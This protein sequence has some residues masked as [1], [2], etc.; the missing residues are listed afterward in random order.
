MESWVWVSSPEGMRA[1]ELTLPLSNGSTRWPCWTSDGELALVVQIRE[2]Q[3]DD[4][5]RDHPGP[6]Q[7]SE[8]S[9]LKIYIILKWLEHMKGS[10]LL[11]QSCSNSMTG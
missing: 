3:Q 10:V 7:G 4:Q 2:I 5:L 9:Y 11:I 6:N 8:L 1:R